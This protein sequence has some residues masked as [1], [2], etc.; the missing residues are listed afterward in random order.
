MYAKVGYVTLWSALEIISF[1]IIKELTEEAFSKIK[2]R[3][4]DDAQKNI[5]PKPPKGF[6]HTLENLNKAKLEKGIPSGKYE[7]LIALKHLGLSPLPFED[8]HYFYKLRSNIL[9][10]LETGSEGEFILDWLALRDLLK[11]VGVYHLGLNKDAIFIGCGIKFR[12]RNPDKWGWP[13]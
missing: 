8:L 3:V 12:N 5:K 7:V 9:H 6:I 11:Y 1:G 2:G 13:K 4:L 10:L